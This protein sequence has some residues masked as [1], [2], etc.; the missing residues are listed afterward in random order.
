[1]HR[2]IQR[3]LQIDAAFKH[4]D[5]VYRKNE[6]GPDGMPRKTRYYVCCAEARDGVMCY[7]LK[8]ELPPSGHFVTDWIPENDLREWPE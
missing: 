5:P 3:L 4:K 2:L 8:D 7:R 6:R 1:M